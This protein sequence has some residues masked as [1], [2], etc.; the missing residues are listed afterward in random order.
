MGK[1]HRPA[2]EHGKLIARVRIGAIVLFKNDP[3]SNAVQFYI[4]NLLERKYPFWGRLIF[5]FFNFMHDKTIKV[6]FALVE[7]SVKT[8]H[9]S[10]VPSRFAK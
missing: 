1:C 10:R 2:T 3:C 9:A 7:I 6:Y 8:K 4:H 5:V